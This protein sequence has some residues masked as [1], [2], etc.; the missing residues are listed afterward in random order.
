MQVTLGKNER[1]SSGMRS[2]FGSMFGAIAAV[3]I[4]IWLTICIGVGLGLWYLSYHLTP[5]VMIAFLTGGGCFAVAYGLFKVF[6]FLSDTASGI[7]ET[8]RFVADQKSDSEGQRFLT[9]Q[10]LAMQQLGTA[11]LNQELKRRNLDRADLAYELQ[12][13]ALQEPDFS[14]VVEG[15]GEPF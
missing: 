7:A 4:T 8:K 5:S 13:K 3:L 6:D 9:Q 10:M 14:P 2:L 15:D 1:R 12:Q 11:Q